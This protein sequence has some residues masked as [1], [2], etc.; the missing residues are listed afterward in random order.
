MA[1]SKT[2]QRKQLQHLILFDGV[3]N[4]CCFWV[5]FLIARDL[6]KSFRFSSLQSAAGQETLKRLG[7]EADTLTTMIFVEGD[8]RHIK[9]SAALHI[10]RHMGGLWPLLFI[11]IAIPAP[12]RDF[13]YD[14]IARNRTRWFG[15]RDSCM[16]PTAELRDRF[17]VE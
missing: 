2:I 12:L 11:F 8:K 10:A 13:L 6:K 15:I 7:L 4:L 17:L 9:S 3:C 14:F 1:G 16:V 5:R